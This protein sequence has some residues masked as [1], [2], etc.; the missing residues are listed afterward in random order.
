M[1]Y[2][3]SGWCEIKAVNNQVGD[4]LDYG[5]CDGGPDLYGNI[6]LDSWSG[7]CF[8]LKQRCIK[9]P[10]LSSCSCEAYRTPTCSCDTQMDFSIGDF[11]EAKDY[12]FLL[13]K[14]NEART[15]HGIGNMSL[16]QATV[17][18]RVDA[19]FINSLIDGL[20][21]ANNA[22]GRSTVSLSNINK[23]IA[24]ETII[25]AEQLKQIVNKAHEIKVHCHCN[26]QCSCENDSP[27]CSCNS[28]S[29]CSCDSKSSCSC[30]I[31]CSGVSL[32]CTGGVSSGCSSLSCG[33]MTC[34]SDYSCNCDTYKPS[35]SCSCT[36]YTCSCHTHTC[37]CTGN[38]IS[39]A[40]STV[41]QA[42][43]SIKNAFSKK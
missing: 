5:H 39:K 34:T 24:Q 17:S 18:Q 15:T 12:N 9:L 28:K 31:N 26:N 37:S 22:V 38:S 41:S 25:T 4:M 42:V 23:A 3:V 43:S 20:I 32:G 21:E 6:I 13:N 36:G 19:N 10:P 35:S 8:Y 1:S 11:I 27:P 30:D 33:S 14:V 16:P 7:E 40:A 29:S 2:T